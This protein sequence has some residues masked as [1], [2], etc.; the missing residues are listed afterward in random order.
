MYIKTHDGFGDGDL[1]HLQELLTLVDVKLSSIFNAARRSPDPDLDGLFD[2]GEYFIGIALTAIQ[3]YITSTY[4]KFK[5]K[6]S[7]ALRLPPNI[8]ERLTLV[9]VLNAGAN[10]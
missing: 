7:E 6:R 5:I 2:T 8:T 3:Q 4:G 1:G 10:F 9:A